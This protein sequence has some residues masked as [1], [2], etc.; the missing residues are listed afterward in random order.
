M[1]TQSDD[2]GDVSLMEKVKN[3]IKAEYKKPGKVFLGLVHRL[4]RPVSGVVVFGRTSKGASRLS[5]QF[6]QKTTQKIY[7]T[8]VEETPEPRKASL[9]HYLRK[10]KSLKVTVFPRPS[11]DAKEALLDYEV[12]ENFKNTSLLDIRL[13]T[14]RFHQ[15]RAQLSFIGYPI[16]GDKKYGASSVLPEGRIALHAQKIVFNHPTSKEEIIINCRLPEDWP[17]I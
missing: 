5:E 1:L 9:R 3:W 15:I 14:G 7:R 6:R 11:P 17:S 12:I 8:L 16:V 10:E 13:H 2:S 4:D